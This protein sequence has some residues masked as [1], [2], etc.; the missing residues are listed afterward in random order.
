MT[1]IH[2]YTADERCRTFRTR[3]RGARGGRDQPD[4]RLDRRRQAIG[5]V[6][7]E[8]QGKLDGFRDPRPVPD[9]LGLTYDRGRP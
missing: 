7:L 8:L 1:T 9:R 2:A 3:T 6:I 5:V 4:P